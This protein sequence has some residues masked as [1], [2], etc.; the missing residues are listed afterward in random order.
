MTIKIT[1][2]KN[3]DGEVILTL[4]YSTSSGELKTV[5]IAK[6]DLV[7]QFKVLIAITGKNPTVQDL[8]NI[9]VQM[10]NEERAG[11]LKIPDTFD[12]TT[13]IGVELEG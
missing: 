10:V 3:S 9:L 11:K 8:K 12:F 4:R 1:Q 2:V 6:E 7:T 5:K 13:Y